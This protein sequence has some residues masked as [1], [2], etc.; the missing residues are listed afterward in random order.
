MSA[1]PWGSALRAVVN[2][3][4]RNPSNLRYT[5]T[6]G[7]AAVALGN[8]ESEVFWVSGLP[9]YVLA[10]SFV[11]F[12]STSCELVEADIAVEARWPYT[13]SNLKADLVSYGGSQ[14]PL[15]AVAMHEFGH[16][17]GLGETAGTYSVMGDALTHLHAN[18]TTARAYPGRD[19]AMGLT[20]IYGL[21]SFAQEDLGIAHWRWTG[22]QGA[23]STHGRTRVFDCAGNKLPE[24]VGTKQPVYRVN[25]GQCV[26]LEL[27]YENLGKTTPLTAAVGYYLSTDC[28]ISTADTLLATT[29]LS[30]RRGAM[31]TV[32]YTLNIPTYL[33]SGTRYCLGAVID[34]YSVINE[35][36]DWNNAS[37]VGIFVN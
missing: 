1:E 11:W 2:R 25:Q 3:W 34:P 32:L 36:Y 5:I 33:S 8:R 29:S 13:A 12:N 20:S 17:G 6:F 9:E 7:D 16:A 31:Q 24:L 35:L 28:E 19:A 10:A 23:Y 21:W 37:Y 15:Q 27:T 30:L 26:R 4:N 14:L 22:S 18:G